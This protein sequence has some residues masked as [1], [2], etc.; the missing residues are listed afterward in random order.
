[1]YVLCIFIIFIYI[2]VHNLNK[3]LCVDTR[4]LPLC[5]TIEWS[6]RIA[7]VIQQ[8]DKKPVPT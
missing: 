3:L 2:L 6:S 8:N 1:M 4:A 7:G 5:C